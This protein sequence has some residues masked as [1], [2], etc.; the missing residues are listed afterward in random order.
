LI[1]IRML[2][3]AI[4]AGA[5]ESEEAEV[6]EDLELLADFVAN[7]GEAAA[8]TVGRRLRNLMR[9]VAIIPYKGYPIR[10]GMAG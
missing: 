5:E 1:S 2:R 3:V 9:L 6:S 4:G 8:T 7:V 10:D